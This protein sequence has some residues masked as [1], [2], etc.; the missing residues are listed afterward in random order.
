MTTER[1]TPDEKS[2]ESKTPQTFIEKLL[3]DEETLRSLLLLP[4]RE[5]ERLVLVRRKENFDFLWEKCGLEK[6]DA[7]EEV[8]K[9][10]D[11]FLE[12]YDNEDV[13]EWILRC[14]AQDALLEFIYE[15]F[16]EEELI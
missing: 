14:E 6:D 12:K 3:E 4:E 16:E 10:E 13:P 1:K 7:L 5:E 9:S 2:V 11:A 8:R 15:Q